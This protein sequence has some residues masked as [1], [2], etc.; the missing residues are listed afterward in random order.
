MKKIYII[1]LLIILSITLLAENQSVALTLKVKGD[2][3][4]KRDGANS[5]LK[6]GQQLFNQDVVT[7]GSD[8]FTALKFID[9]SS[10]LKLY[11]NS[12]LVINSEKEDGKLSKK[13]KLN[14]GELWSKVTKN[15]GAYELET[16]TTVVSV[17]GTEFIVS[18]SEEGHTTLF[19]IEGKVNIRNKSDGNSEDVEAGY[20]AF[21]DGSGEIEV[22]EYD[23]EELPEEDGESETMEIR[24]LNDEGEEKLI[25][26]EVE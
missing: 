14:M 21:S 24:L 20:R 2:V 3:D 22:S 17:K 10:L 11:P 25:I 12:V 9:G 4:L 19:T 23:P 8:A 15:T 16:P 1:I 18:V 26:I 7:T 13:N 6:T 5:M